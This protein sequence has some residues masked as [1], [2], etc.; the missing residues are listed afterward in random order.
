ME[1]SAKV[2]E[3]HVA[4]QASANASITSSTEKSHYR[5]FARV[6]P[7]LSA[8]GDRK[9]LSLRPIPM[10][11]HG[12]VQQNSQP[13]SISE[14]LRPRFLERFA[15]AMLPGLLMDAG[16]MVS[17]FAIER[18][19]IHSASQAG[20]D[21]RLLCLYLF[22]FVIFS[23]EEKLYSAKKN[24]TVSE[25]AAATR[26]LAWATLLGSLSLHW[27]LSRAALSALAAFT[28]ANLLTL[29]AV[30]WISHH[31]RRGNQH[32]KNVLI[33]GSGPRAQQIADAIHRDA[34]SGRQAKGF[35]PENHLRNIYGPA[36]LSRIAREEFVDELLVASTDP[37]IVEIAVQ[38]ARHNLLDVSI[39]PQFSAGF[40]CD[41]VVLQNAGGVALLAISNYPPPEYALA[42]K[43]IFDA[44]L[45]IFA[46]FVLSPLLV[47]I[48]LAIKLDSPGPVLYRASR[49]GRK[50][51]QF[52]CYKFRT[53]VRD[54]DAAKHKLR[55]QNQRQGA[56]FKI[57]DDPR[58]TRTGRFLRRYSLDELP[59]L[60]NVFV[61]DMSL[62][63]P[64]PHPPD[65]VSLYNVQ[66]LQRLDFVPGI[67][68]L[69]QVT[70]RR[71]PSFER[72]VALD[73]EYIRRWNLWLDLRILWR[74]IFAVL[75]G[76]GA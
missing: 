56:F 2:V 30:R 32:V 16:L 29:L 31:S 33:I 71:D 64:R 58:I 51:Q 34:A 47:V 43:R 50:G 67:T 66:D 57:E 63:G 48:G 4:A 68:G 17:T 53:M 45:A 59:Q 73:V 18:W 39:A 60:W 13:Y 8:R 65:D 41:D 15:P 76:S 25:A 20:L 55:S 19:R 38:E 61:G 72:S 37:S 69:W 14:E 75:Q 70:A 3:F 52:F 44:A 40:K 5:D 28:G 22:A 9:P 74:T 1:D 42:I 7:G 54:A 24:S 49:I 35:M 11:V 21:S 23:V 36:M 12:Q 10:A 27:P 26:A 46:L 6:I 62:V